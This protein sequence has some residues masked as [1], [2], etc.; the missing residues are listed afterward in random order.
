MDEANTRHLGELEQSNAALNAAK[1]LISML[2]TSFHPN[3]NAP[4]VL[5]LADLANNLMLGIQA[6]FVNHKILLPHREEI[7]RMLQ[8]MKELYGEIVNAHRLVQ[9]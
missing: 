5:E 2:E 8:K 1:G 7:E 9:E 3:K 4:K 6:T